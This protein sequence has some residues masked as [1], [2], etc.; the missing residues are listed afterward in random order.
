[1]S[2]TLITNA[3]LVNEGRTFEGDLRIENDRIAQIGKG[4]TPRDGEQVVDAA[5][6]WLLPGM[7][8]D[9]VHFREPGLTH[10][11]D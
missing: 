11:G 2:S 8:D 5:G 1:M 3:R 6:R 7:I 4:L 9:Q 10:K